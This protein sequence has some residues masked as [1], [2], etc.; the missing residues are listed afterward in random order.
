MS[1]H[2]CIRLD[3]QHAKRPEVVA[4]ADELR[5]DGMLCQDLNKP[6]VTSRTRQIYCPPG[7]KHLF[8]HRFKIGQI[9]AIPSY[10]WV[11]T[12]GYESGSTT[13]DWMKRVI[14]VQLVRIASEPRSGPMPG[15][16]VFETESKT[17]VRFSTYGAPF[18][19]IHCDIE[20]LGTT[21]DEGLL[22]YCAHRGSAKST[23]TKVKIDAIKRPVS[24]LSSFD[25]YL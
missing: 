21:K 2:S 9:I 5:I 25:E 1:C 7:V 22:E 12:D 19:A 13:S 3:S 18:K 10:T 11:T 24:R 20:L 4:A 8:V 16:A 6:K 23:A 15:R 17:D 14:S